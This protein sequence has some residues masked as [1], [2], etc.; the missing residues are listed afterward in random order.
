MPAPQ[1]AGNRS[2]NLNNVLSGASLEDNCV[3][4]ATLIGAGGHKDV[5]GCRQAQAGGHESV[6]SHECCRLQAGT[7]RCDLRS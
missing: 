3:E 1:G 5:V 2:P 7:G 6:L 4:A